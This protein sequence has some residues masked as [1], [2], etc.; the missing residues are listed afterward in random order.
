MLCV[1]NVKIYIIIIIHVT[2]VHQVYLVFMC[3][4]LDVHM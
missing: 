2:F 1:V 4:I 3:P